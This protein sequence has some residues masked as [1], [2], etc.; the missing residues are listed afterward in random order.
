MGLTE[1]APHFLLQTL[2]LVP[3]TCLLTALTPSPRCGCW[4]GRQ[5][6]DFP[7]LSHIRCLCWVN[8]SWREPRPIIQY[9]Y[10]SCCSHLKAIQNTV[11]F[12][13]PSSLELLIGVSCCELLC[14]NH[15]FTENHLP[16]SQP[17]ERSCPFPLFPSQDRG[18]F[19][20]L[21][22]SVQWI[23][24]SCP[25][26]LSDLCPQPMECYECQLVFNG[27]VVCTIIQQHL[28]PFPSHLM[29]MVCI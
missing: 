3:F 11:N 10:C 4:K 23:H 17:R 7:V 16:W 19:W 15:A 13:K 18:R 29:L 20:V 14:Q 12:H 28:F 8:P 25:W 9:I 26:M 5:C 6:L 24:P 2:H 27:K 21:F 22:I 1:H